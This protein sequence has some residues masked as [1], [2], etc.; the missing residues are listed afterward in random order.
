MLR[1]LVLRLALALV[2]ACAV[3]AFLAWLAGRP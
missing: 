1:E 2:A 3:I